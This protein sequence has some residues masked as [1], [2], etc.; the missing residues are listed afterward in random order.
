MVLARD[1]TWPYAL[2]CETLLIVTKVL[3]GTTVITL[4]MYAHGE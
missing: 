1:V 2:Y 3:K 4:Q